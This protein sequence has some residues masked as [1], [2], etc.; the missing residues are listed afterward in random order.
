MRVVG[1]YHYKV[2]FIGN[3]LDRYESSKNRSKKPGGKLLLKPKGGESSLRDAY[4]V[5]AVIYT[6]DIESLIN[7]LEYPLNEIISKRYFEG[8]VSTF[9]EDY[10]IKSRREARKLIVRAVNKF[11]GEVERYRRVSKKIA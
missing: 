11:F 2:W 10:G 3:V 6:V 1:P 4:F 9:M 7:K 8:D 5:D